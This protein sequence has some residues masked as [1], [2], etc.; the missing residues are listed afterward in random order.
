MSEVT[1][2]ILVACACCHLPDRTYDPATHRRQGNDAGSDTVK[3]DSTV[4]TGVRGR[5][6]YQ[7]IVNRDEILIILNFVSNMGEHDW[8]STSERSRIQAQISESFRAEARTT[9]LRLSPYRSST[10]EE[11]VR[12]GCTSPLNVVFDKDGISEDP[13]CMALVARR[14]S[15]S[16]LLSG[17]VDPAGDLYV[18]DAQL[19]SASDPDNPR[20]VKFMFSGSQDVAESVRIAWK[21][22][23]VH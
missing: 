8:K 23:V 3:E 4:N 14:L 16:W 13:K 20:T 1:L 15:T 17:F 7:C 2:L 11:R 18:V 6:D 12:G 21:Q 9:L 5:A 10:L 19:V 22:L